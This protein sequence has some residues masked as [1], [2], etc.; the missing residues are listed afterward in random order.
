MSSPPRLTQANL[1]KL[2]ELEGTTKGLKSPPPEKPEE[3]SKMSSSKG[4]KSPSPG[5]PEEAS[6]VSSSKGLKSPPP[7]KPEEDPKP[8]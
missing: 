6:K 7:E 8:V 4:L 2:Q 3:D 1:E 5:K